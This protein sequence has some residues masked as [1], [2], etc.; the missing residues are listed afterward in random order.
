MQIKSQ[1]SRLATL[2]ALLALAPASTTAQNPI[3]ASIANG[4][5]QG[6]VDARSSGVPS[7]EASAEIS[8]LMAAF[9]GNTDVA[10]VLNS[11]VSVVV[12]GINTSNLVELAQQAMSSF[13]AFSDSD[14]FKTVDA[15]ISAKG[16]NYDL[17]QALIN[18]ESN[19]APVFA[20]ITPQIEALPSNAQVDGAVNSVLVIGAGLA[21]QVGSIVS[22]SVTA[23]IVTSVSDV[24]G[25]TASSAVAKA[26]S[27]VAKASSAVE[28]AMSLAES[29]SSAA[30][31]SADESASAAISSADESASAAV[32]SAAESASAAISSARASVSAAISSARASLSATVSA[33][34]NDAN[35]A[36]ALSG[37]FV[38]GGAA[39]AVA[40]YL[41]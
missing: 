18:V 40:N 22:Q 4:I 7:A 33:S 9:T 19:L 23:S 21:A 35:N 1:S 20:L 37:A 34:E 16:S 2:A 8:S 36:R 24:G 5:S 27:A 6:I 29:N 32:S 11:A 15:M 26:S 31:S 30:A 10:N 39:I 12:G 28:S 25:D 41:L 3:V 14:N 17:D 13:A 38:M